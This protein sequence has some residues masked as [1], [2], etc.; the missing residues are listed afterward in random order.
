MGLGH[1]MCYVTNQSSKTY[2]FK[3]SECDWFILMRSG[4][5]NLVSVRVWNLISWQA[6][7]QE[8]RTAQYLTWGIPADPPLS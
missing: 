4:P 7:R 5:N 6:G 3:V 8:P 2:L 1:I